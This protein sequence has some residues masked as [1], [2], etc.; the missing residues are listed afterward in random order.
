MAKT[1]SIITYK[2]NPLS[3]LLAKN[4][5]KVAYINLVNLVLERE[6][7]PEFLQGACKAEFLAAALEDLLRDKGRRQRQK[8]AYE[9]ALKG[10]G[11]DLKNG[12]SPSMRAA[13]VVLEVINAQKKPD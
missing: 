3:Y 8:E 9:T 5:F 4:L 13:D 10:L 6:A 7:I 2:I 12:S 1:P 11:Q